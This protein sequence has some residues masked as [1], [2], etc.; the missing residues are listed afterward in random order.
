MLVILENKLAMHGPVNVKHFLYLRQNL[1]GSLRDANYCNEDNQHRRFKKQLLSNTNR[2]VL[3]K[4][5]TK[6]TMSQKGR[7]I[8]FSLYM[9]LRHVE[10]GGLELRS[11]LNSA[12]YGTDLSDSRPGRFISMQRNPGTH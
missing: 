7:K 9:T 5:F 2:T 1:R 10:G 6:T 12:L 8:K 11:F 4:I 3:Y